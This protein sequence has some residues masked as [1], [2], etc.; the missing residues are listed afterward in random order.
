MHAGAYQLPLHGPLP[1]MPLL[2]L[3]I[4]TDG[5]LQHLRTHLQSVSV[6][7]SVRSSCM[8]YTF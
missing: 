5:A 3:Q 4:S 7:V 6:V 8:R 1:R 2:S